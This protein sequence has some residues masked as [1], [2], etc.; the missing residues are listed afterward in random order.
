MAAYVALLADQLESLSYPLTPG[1]KRPPQPSATLSIGKVV[2][3]L[4]GPPWNTKLF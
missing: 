4:V 1:F 2:E 3:E